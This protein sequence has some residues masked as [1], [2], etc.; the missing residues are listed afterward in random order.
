M[1]SLSWIAALALL[2]AA[3]DKPAAPPEKPS[4]A[5]ESLPPT[6]RAEDRPAHE[7]PY[8]AFGAP[9]AKRVTKKRSA[10][11]VH[12]ADGTIQTQGQQKDKAACEDHGGV[13]EKSPR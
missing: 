9:H 1:E 13:K 4:P 11:R 5:K 7:S 3:A 2:T 10:K 8:S 6:Q 12:C